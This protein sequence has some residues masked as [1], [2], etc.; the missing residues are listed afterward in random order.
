MADE[1]ETEEVL[2]FTGFTFEEVDDSESPFQDVPN[3]KAT[4][5]K[6]VRE[7]LLGTKTETK[8]KAA[9]D[10]RDDRKKKPLPPK[11]RGQWVEPVTQLYTG[12]GFVLMPI[13]PVCANGFITVAPQVAEQWDELAYQNDAVRR[14]LYNLTTTSVTTKLIL[15]HMPL[16]AAIA[17]HHVPAAQMLMGKMGQDMAEKIAEQM[18]ANKPADGASE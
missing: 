18:N 8:R 5:R 11:R 6:S 1:E 10:R 2:G 7:N 12:I 13:D 4:R 9:G 16:I 15:A 3:A 17:L 14:F